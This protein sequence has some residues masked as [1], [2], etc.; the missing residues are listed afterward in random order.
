[1]QPA[2][3]TRRI[4]I[5]GIPGT[6]FGIHVPYEPATC[7]DRESREQANANGGTQPTG[8]G[9]GDRPDGARDDHHQEIDTEH[10]AQQLRHLLDIKLHQQKGGRRQQKISHRKQQDDDGGEGN[11]IWHHGRP[12]FFPDRAGFFW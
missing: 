6:E 1:M 8:Q 7:P 11:G 3:P 2:Q 9:N 5:A 12:L 10:A 4:G